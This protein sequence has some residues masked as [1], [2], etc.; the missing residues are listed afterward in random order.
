MQEVLSKTV[1]TNAPLKDQEF[2]ELR[3]DDSDNIWR[4]R[5]MIR[6]A[7]VHWDSGFGRFVWDE[8]LVEYALNRE[9]AREQYEA[10]RAA[11]VERGFIYSDMDR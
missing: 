8:P 9:V 1:D 10:R 3:L 6:E 5:C 11:L 4:G 2:Y 7:R